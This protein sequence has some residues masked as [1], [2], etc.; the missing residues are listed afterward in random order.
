[1]LRGYGGAAGSVS[2]EARSIAFKRAAALRDLLVSDGVPK[3]RIEVRAMGGI[4]DRGEPDRVDIF[5]RTN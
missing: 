1:V 3:A 2:P 4:D 5:L